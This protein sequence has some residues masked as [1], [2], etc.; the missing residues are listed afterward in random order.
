MGK[1]TKLTASGPGD[2]HAA[3]TPIYLLQTL[4]HDP[5]G[6]IGYRWPR[7]WASHATIAHVAC[8]RLDAIHQQ[9]GEIAV[10]A[11]S[12]SRMIDE[13]ALL[14]EAYDC[15]TSMVSNVV[16]AVRHLAY[17]MA[18]ENHTPLTGTRV[19]DEIR[20]ATEAAG[21]DCRVGSQGYEG[22]SE[23]VRVRD[24]IE[25]P[26]A[27]NVYQGDDSSWDKVPLAWLLSDRSIKAYLGYREWLDPVVSDWQSWLAN[28]PQQP[29]TWNVVR[30]AGSRYPAKKPRS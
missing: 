24:A 3:G 2:T 25:H 21:I 10:D 23:I 1:S 5:L 15:G 4:V 27:A 20:Q 30:G 11:R 17:T 14:L 9:V 26:D 18:S 16:R 28:R 22:L 29:T 12:N 8:Q 13:D 6:T 19:L 7:L